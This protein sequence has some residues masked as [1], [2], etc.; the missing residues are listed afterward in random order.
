MM[1]C[2]LLF[3]LPRPSW[4]QHPPYYKPRHCSLLICQSSTPRCLC[5]VSW[6]QPPRLLR[7]LLR[8]S[9]LLQLQV[10]FR[11]QLIP[12][13]LRQCRFSPPSSLTLLSLT[14]QSSRLSI[15]ACQPITSNWHT[16]PRRLA[17]HL[18]PLSRSQQHH[19]RPQPISRS[20]LSPSD[21]SQFTLWPTWEALCRPTFQPCTPR[22]WLSP[23]PPWWAT[24]LR[25]SPITL[26]R[27]SRLILKLTLMEAKWT[28]QRWWT[29]AAP[30]W[31]NPRRCLHLTRSWLDRLLSSTLSPWLRSQPSQS[32]RWN[33]PENDLG[34]RQLK[35]HNTHRNQLILPSILYSF[36]LPFLSTN[37]ISSAFSGIHELLYLFYSLTGEKRE[38]LS[39]SPQPSA[40]FVFMYWWDRLWHP[41]GLMS[42]AGLRA[43]VT[44]YLWVKIA[45]RRILAEQQFVRKSSNSHKNHTGIRKMPI[46]YS[47]LP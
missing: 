42:L 32:A 6:L 8:S 19:R 22:A 41:G 25:P 24:S 35:N 34:I 45:E 37:R 5:L 31:E 4:N 43:A 7:H 28:A 21:T 15:T 1:R 29:R 40:H 26:C 27:M 18:P 30:R 2:P 39:L 38:N 3:L 12:S 10:P 46:C 44:L 17:P 47:T 13:S 23:S 11:Y 33:W 14:R 36:L 16:S 9:L 20:P